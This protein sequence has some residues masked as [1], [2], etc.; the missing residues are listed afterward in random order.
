MSSMLRHAIASVLLVIA[1][2]IEFPARAQDGGLTAAYTAADWDK[3]RADLVARAPGQMAQAVDRW[4]QLTAS[5]AFAFEDYASFLLTYP[6]L[7]DATKL[8]GYAEDRLQS[9]YVAPDRLLAFFDKY[10]PVT[11]YARARYA[12]A[13]M[14]LRPAAALETA[15]A[16]WRGGQM[17]PTAES[18]L[19]AM[20]GRYFTQEDHDA[21]MD[22]LLW[23]RD[24]AAAARQIVYVSP[25]RRPLDQA[26]LAILQG[27]DGFT[28]A[29]TAMADP[30]YL[31]NRSRELRTEGRARE[32]VALLANRPRLAS[33]PF[34]QSAWIAELLNV[35]RMAG[36]RDAERIAAAA[37]DAFAP[38]VDISD[39][40]Y[41]LRDD[42]TSLMWLGGTSA[43]WQLGDAAGA[44]PLFYRYGAAARTSPTRSKGFFWAG[45]AAQKAGDQ[46]GA[47]R[48]FE[49]AAQ[50][51]DRF[52]GQLALERLGRPLTFPAP[53]TVV[54]TP[55]ERAAFLAEPLTQAVTE[56]AR[57]A[58][59][60]V[61]IKF[62]RE[63][64]NQADTLADHVLVAQLARDIGR[65]DLAVILSDAADSDGYAGFTSIGY[66][67]LAAPPG[68]DWTMVHAISRQESQFA[69]N[70]I[71]HAGA[72]GLM[73]LM[74]GTAREQAGKSGLEYL[75]ASLVTD[76]AYNLRLGDGYFQ[77]ML[78]YYGGSYPLAVAA[79]NAGPGNVNKWL[80]ANG[81]PRTGAVPWIDWIEKIPFY[82][83]KNYVQRVLE[84]AVVYETLHPDKAPGGRART[85]S[86]FLR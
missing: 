81:D 35:A 60:S 45:L 84:N 3:A 2:G 56:V 72:R 30:G 71:S 7:P 33:L 79:Y 39:K 11:N 40:A 68:T 15:R 77:R 66:P 16:A 63:I 34:D 80:S 67:T 32:A 46:A 24:A 27:G 73:Q 54:P 47:R 37:D 62:Y 61:G 57:D 49:M 4:Q 22:A 19:L 5:K 13:Q 44:A 43:L 8:Q 86:E 31:Y 28:T 65:R 41:K 29:P 1:T 12:L 38:G 21:R 53:P 25:A 18:S 20:Y 6:G 55:Q 23:Q 76:P 10:P 64:A 59:W 75:S 83:T 9:E 70:A 58:P 78:N 82:E 69:S 42:Y 74:P 36:A 50:Y 52:Y 26:R 51:P 85:V 48:Y 17:D 14:T